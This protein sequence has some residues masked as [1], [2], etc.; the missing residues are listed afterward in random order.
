MHAP[1]F[2]DPLSDRPALLCAR[3]NGVDFH[4]PDMAQAWADPYAVHLSVVCDRC[5]TKNHLR[6]QWRLGRVTITQ[7]RQNVREL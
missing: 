7:R 5:G 3:C 1:F 2:D 4:R 6:M